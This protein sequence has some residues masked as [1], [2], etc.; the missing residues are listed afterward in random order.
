MDCSKNDGAERA[1]RVDTCVLYG[2]VLSGKTGRIYGKS[3][4]EG[5]AVS[6]GLNATNHRPDSMAHF[7]ST[8]SLSRGE[9]HDDDPNLPIVHPQLGSHVRT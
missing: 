9:G 4:L 2:S 5:Y 7:V 8:H 3:E 6:G 1:L